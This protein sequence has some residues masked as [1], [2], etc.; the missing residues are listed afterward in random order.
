MDGGGL[1]ESYL[2][3][4]LPYTEKWTVARGADW[5]SNRYV[6]FCG[7]LRWM[8]DDDD[9]STERR[10]I[11]WITLIWNRGNVKKQTQALSPLSGGSSTA[12]WA[13]ELTEAST[14]C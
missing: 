12:P 14:G 1:R 3:L 5:R 10:D 9:A 2:D 4:R 11:L 13:Q 8:G 7:W 6:A